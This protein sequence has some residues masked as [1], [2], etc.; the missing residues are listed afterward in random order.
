MLVA[1]A[2]ACG[3]ACSRTTPVPT[4]DIAASLAVPRL[5]GPVFDP[6]VL[7]GRP[8]LVTFWR[9][10]CVHCEAEL[11]QLA[12]TARAAGVPAVA[13]AMTRKTDAIRAVIDRVG[14]DGIVLVDD[15]TLR[16]RYQVTKVPY[17]LVLR[18]DGTAARALLGAHGGPALA[19]A[20]SEAR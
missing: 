11:P 15:G 18:P 7:R 14:F 4:G 12:A 6:Q 10:G 13:V 9:P 1:V 2:L 8:A 16:R 20:L 17:T 3:L 5:D 19:A